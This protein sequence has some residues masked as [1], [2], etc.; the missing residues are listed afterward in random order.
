M[1]I[2]TN[3]AS[4]RDCSGTAMRNATPVSLLPRIAIARQVHEMFLWPWSKAWDI[5]TR[6]RPGVGGVIATL[7]WN[8]ITG[9]TTKSSY[10][11]LS[12]CRNSLSLSLSAQHS[13]SRLVHVRHP[14]PSQWQPLSWL[15]QHRPKAGTDSA[16]GQA[17]GPDLPLQRTALSLPGQ[18]C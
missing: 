11:S 17:S 16:A 10:R 14:H 2:M 8:Q 5:L 12:S 4:M 6:Q 13:R 7:F 1:T 3:L 9:Q 18:S 15:N